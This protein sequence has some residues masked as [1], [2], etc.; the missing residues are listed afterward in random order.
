M[1]AGAPLALDPVR[2]GAF[3]L[4]DGL[5]ELD[6]PEAETDGVVPA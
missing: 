6:A 3:P 1:D 5:D 2:A 4:G